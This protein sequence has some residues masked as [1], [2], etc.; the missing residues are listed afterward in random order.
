VDRP[1][2]L[3]LMA[4]QGRANQALHALRAVCGAA[5]PRRP[6]PATCA[7]VACRSRGCRSPGPIAVPAIAA[8][9]AARTGCQPRPRDSRRAAG[10]LVCLSLGGN[11]N[12]SLVT[13]P[14]RHSP[15]INALHQHVCG[16]PLLRHSGVGWSM[17]KPGTGDRT[18]HQT[19]RRLLARQVRRSST[20]YPCCQFAIRHL[21]WVQFCAG[22]M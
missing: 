4:G 22:S 2:N 21:T 3:L 1:G 15:P 13:G 12:T 18:V 19:G 7:G 10:H 16:K 6:V 20:P 5:R 14:R 17:L 11:H 9:A 8:R